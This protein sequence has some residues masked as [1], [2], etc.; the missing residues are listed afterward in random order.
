MNRTLILSFAI[1][2]LL[3]CSAFAA[4]TVSKES[5]IAEGVTMDPVTSAKNV[6]VKTKGQ[7]I[8]GFGIGMLVGSALG[9]GAA[10][11]QDAL[12]I[13]QQAGSLTQQAINDYGHQ[14]VG[15]LGPAPVM[16]DALQEHLKALGVPVRTGE[17]EGGYRIALQQKLWSLQY[18]GM[19]KENYRL[20]YAIDVALKAPNGTKADKATCQGESRRTPCRSGKRTSTR[21]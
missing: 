8:A 19:F 1:A 3:P 9:S 15:L 5:L 14:R 16:Q 4:A 2:C 20:V 7:R 10:N 18:V 12:E 21:A 13:G 6:S 11:P 17:A